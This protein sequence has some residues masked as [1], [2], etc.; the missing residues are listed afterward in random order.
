LV[1]ASSWLTP[2]GDPFNNYRCNVQG[3]SNFCA[4]NLELFDLRADEIDCPNLDLS[5]DVVNIGCLG[6][7][8]GVNVSFFSQDLGFLGTVQTKGALAAGA[9]ET[10]TLEAAQQESSAMIWAIV[11][12]DMLGQGALNECDEDNQS[13]TVLVCIP[14]G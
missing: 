3:G 11:D 9:K 6:V 10:V 1:E 14:I 8:P 2:E 4:P 12:E 5:V 13:E 7:G